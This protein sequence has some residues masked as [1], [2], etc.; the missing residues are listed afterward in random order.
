MSRPIPLPESVPD[1]APIRLDVAA[2][3]AF[4]DGTMTAAGLRR[5]SARG[6]LAINR[7]AGK[8]YTTLAAVR[9]MIRKCRVQPKERASGLDRQDEISRESSP[10]RPHG[11]SSTPANSIPL[12]AAR[13]IVE[14]LKGRSTDTSAKSTKRHAANAP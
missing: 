4:P 7:I 12:A 10:T 6:R 2:A 1:S 8:D 9:E 3:L 11:S 5:E 13:L 14:E